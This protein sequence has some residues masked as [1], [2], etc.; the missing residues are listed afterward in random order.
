MSEKEKAE[1]DSGSD[2]DICSVCSGK[3]KR[4]LEK[5]KKDSKKLSD[6]VDKIKKAKTKSPASKRLTD[7]WK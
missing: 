1:I 7:A 5:Y 3:Y 6:L 2:E 4:E